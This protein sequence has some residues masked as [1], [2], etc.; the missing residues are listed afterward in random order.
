V[1]LN[2]PQK[3]N[4]EGS[5]PDRSVLFLKPTYREKAD[6]FTKTNPTVPGAF[7]ERTKVCSE[8]PEDSRVR[9]RRF[10]LLTSNR[11][12]TWLIPSGTTRSRN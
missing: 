6:L 2:T 5:F 11:L 9:V 3:N 12:Q 8:V 7:R 4:P 1:D 10:W